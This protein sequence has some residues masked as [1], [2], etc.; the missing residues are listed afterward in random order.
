MNKV[1]KKVKKVYNPIEKEMKFQKALEANEI[2]KERGNRATRRDIQFKRGRF[3][4]LK[5]KP[6]VQQSSL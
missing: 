3:A 6:K 5:N 2:A 1:S 4:F